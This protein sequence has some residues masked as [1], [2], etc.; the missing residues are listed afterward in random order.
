MPKP[1]VCLNSGGF[2]D[3]EYVQ[4]YA[5]AV[6]THIGHPSHYPDGDLYADFLP[7]VVG[8]DQPKPPDE[9]FR[10]VF[11]CGPKTTV[12][13]ARSPQEY[14]D[15]LVA[16]TGEEYATIGWVELWERIAE[17]LRRQ[18]DEYHPGSFR[19]M[20]DGT[21]QRFYKDQPIPGAG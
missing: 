11:I 5:Q 4:I 1:A 21:I 10:A 2:F 16:M 12:G 18:L 7:P 13:T 6:S 20:P 14:V 19:Y 15:P 9:P 3:D 8:A 17:G